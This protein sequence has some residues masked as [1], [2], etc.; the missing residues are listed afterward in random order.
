MSDECFDSVDRR[1]TI[2]PQDHYRGSHMSTS[3]YSEAYV[4]RV[5]T[6]EELAASLAHDV[7]QPITA[8]VT[9]ANTCVR[10]LAGDSPNIQEARDAAIRSAKDGTRAAE[11]IGRIRLLFKKG[12][13]DRELVDVN[14]VIR[15]MIVLLR[16][17]AARYA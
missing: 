13:T 4:S 5:T 7:N 12:T 16:G 2:R 10:W 14:E 15:E 17:E 8:A 11:I 6:M 3:N 9:N 1:R